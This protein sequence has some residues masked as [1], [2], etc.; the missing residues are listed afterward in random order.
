MSRVI[1]SVLLPAYNAERFITSSVESVLTQSFQHF[2]LLLLDNSSTDRTQEIV[3]RYS[4]KRLKLIECPHSFV[5]ALNK[6]IEIAQGKY[7]A[8]MDADDVMHVDRLRIQYSL[9]E[10]AP[11]IDLCSSWALCRNERTGSTKITRGFA[12]LV[13]LP[14]IEFLA[15][16]F[17]MHPT[18]MMRNSY[19]IE[20]NLKYSEGYPGAEDYK[21]WI[22]MALRGATLYIEPEP[23]ILYRLHDEQIS[24]QKRY[25]QIASSIRVQR[26]LLEALL[27]R[28]DLAS[29]RAL[30]EHGL[31]LS[32]K[33]LISEQEFIQWFK[34][35]L[36][37][38]HK[39][40]VLHKKD[41]VRR[42]DKK[43]VSREA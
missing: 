16:N 36:L 28:E 33:G 29:Y 34:S 12:G 19:L 3:R 25:E 5:A 13:E 18:V 14:E 38:Y 7:I 10:D 32:S 22:D 39:K 42:S 9:M 24:V 21:L 43:E 15:M 35:Q 6:G 8:R 41:D 30:V 4:D 20:H 40:R 31:T 37:Q 2:E 23:L 17:I 1:I 27:E 11:D 26:E